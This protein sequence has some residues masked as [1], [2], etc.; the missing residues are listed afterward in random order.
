MENSDREDGISVATPKTESS[1][2]ENLS[3]SEEY[4]NILGSARVRNICLIILTVLALGGV[5]YLLRNVLLPF[6]L[7]VFLMFV[8]N[9][10]VRIMMKRLRMPRVLA[11]LITICLSLII[12]I[13]LATFVSSSF[14]Q[15][16][17]ESPQFGQN[18]QSLLQRIF[19]HPLAEQYGVSR[20][21]AMNTIAPKIAEGAGQ[22][23]SVLVSGMFMLFSQGIIV[24]IYVVF[25]MFSSNKKEEK[26]EAQHSVWNKIRL[27]IESYIFLK[28]VLSGFMA[29]LT[30]IILAAI[31]VKMAAV[32]ALLA[33]AFNFVPNVGPI[34]ATLTPVPIMLLSG[35]SSVTEILLAVLLPGII[36]FVVGHLVEPKVMGSSLELD[37]VVILLGLMLAELM[38]GPVGMLLA[39]PLMVVARILLDQTA[40]TRP[41]V[42]LL[43]GKFPG[44]E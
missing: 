12:L 8:L 9:P 37:P 4:S 36:H 31:G 44:S 18:L 6:V 14:L 41:L 27:S 38:W 3:R 26:A 17:N 10:V 32:V 25:L 30:W 21:V 15:L 7:A 13:G 40:E 35:Q 23:A 19:S 28:T 22:L 29:A 24:T 11:I 34:A 39:M 42:N 20:A 33:F 43:A 1:D 5:S 16:A 2:N